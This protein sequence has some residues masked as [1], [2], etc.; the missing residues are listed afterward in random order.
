[1]VAVI[2]E[3]L[4]W[5]ADF[6]FSKRKT[7]VGTHW[8]DTVSKVEYDY[9]PLPECCAYPSLWEARLRKSDKGMADCTISAYLRV[10]LKA[11]YGLL[12]IGREIDRIVYLSDYRWKDVSM[13]EW[14]ESWRK[15]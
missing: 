6:L 3:F 5:L 10:P 13:T 11:F 12:A 9:H 1:M 7:Y 4:V 14:P 2:M 15:A 8:A